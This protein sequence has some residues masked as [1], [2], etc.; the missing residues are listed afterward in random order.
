LPGSSA[1]TACPFG[2]IDS[3]L[4]GSPDLECR[5]KPQRKIDRIMKAFHEGKLLAKPLAAGEV[6]LNALEAC[7][8]APLAAIEDL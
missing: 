3:E 7:Q 4:E 2:T 5:S 1:R 6:D 8:P